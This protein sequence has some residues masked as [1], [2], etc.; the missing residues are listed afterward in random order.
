MKEELEMMGRTET[1]KHIHAQSVYMCG[2]I[3]MYMHLHTHYLIGWLVGGPSQYQSNR[4][5]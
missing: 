2:G 5:S 3:A 4:I 1:D